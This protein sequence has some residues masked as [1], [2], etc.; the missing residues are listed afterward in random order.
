MKRFIVILSFLSGIFSILTAG[1]TGK[2]AGTV[3]D[4]Q[5]GEPLIGVNIILKGTHLGAATDEDGYY[6]II[7]IPPGEYDLEA[8]YL[9]YHTVIIKKVMVKVD[10]TTEINIKMEP[11]SIKGPTIEVVAQN[12]IIQK[13]ITSTRKITSGKEMKSLP[14]FESTQDVF[15]LYGG[16]ILDLRPQTLQLANGTRIQVRDESLR[17]V[18]IRGG[19]GGEILYLVDGVPVTHPIYGGRSVLDLNI[20]DVQEIELLTGAFNAEYGQAQSGVINITTRSGGQK[21]QGGIEYKTDRLGVFGESYNTDYVSFFASGP[22]PLSNKIFPQLKIKF[23]GEMFFFLSG[24]FNLTDTPYNNHRTREVISFNGIK[25]RERQENDANLNFKLTWNI[26]TKLRTDIS[27]HGAWKKWSN[28]DWLWKN[29]PDHMADF[30]RSTQ[31]LNLKFSHTLSKSTF[32]NL[33]IGFLGVKYDGSLNGMKPPDFWKF[34]KDSSDYN[35]GIWYDYEE[36]EKKFQPYQKPFKV[37]SSIKS[38]TFDPLTGFFDSQ[39]YDNLWRDDATKTLTLR[40]NLSSQ[41]HPEHFVKTGIELQ[42]N[43]LQYIDIQDGGVKLSLYGIAKYTSSQNRPLPPRPPGPFPEF[44]QNRW[45]FRVKP[46]M[47]AWYIQDKFEKETLI[48]NA[49]IRLDWFYLGKTIMNRDWKKQ[50]ER[51]TGLQSNWKVLKYKFSPRF[52]ISFPISEDMVV[53]FSYGHFNQLPELQFYYRDPYTGSFTGNPHLDYEQTILYEFGL[54]RRISRNWAIDI[55][56]YNKDISK[57]VGTT[58]LRGNLG[59]PVYLY[60]NKGYAR[61]RGI[62]IE[63]K[64]RYFK[65]IGGRLNYTV[66]WATGYSSS[67][68]DDYIRSITDFPNPIRERRVNW[69]VR[70]QVIFE[71]SIVIPNKIYRIFGIPFPGGW[72]LTIL[73]RF[74]SGYPY[75]PG[76]ND[77]VELQ[78]K[79]NAA[80][81][82]FITNTDIKFKKNWK[83]YKSSRLTMYL[84]IFNVFNVKNVRIGYG[85]NPWTGKP[86]RFGDVIDDS[87]QLYDWYTMYRLMDPRQFSTGRY[88]KLGVEFN[89]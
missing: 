43:D 41:I 44:G 81:G 76:S 54:T 70:H 22:E 37:E 51:V 25:F 19:R 32:Y 38:P 26:S 60:D 63:L 15:L 59:V 69:D 1:N 4:K 77:I 72:E 86:Y 9:G 64:K 11:V 89:F 74:S 49:G 67:A 56:G 30:G 23:P 8:S 82:P 47:G 48:L 73:S 20:D 75:T 80:T 33:N 17:N 78:T 61:A 83:I 79:E 85:F 7:Q 53:F 2:I 50:W 21:F 55:K 62:E 24:N 6:Y 18:H 29:Y 71:S 84:D 52:G 36:W 35:N 3:V 46:L 16:A 66:Q 27:Y 34:Y 87:P 40:L 10:L 28:F 88:T 12:K 14:G 5:T 57:Q 13:D 45:T 39:G 65:G 31:N 58:Q 42:G 68:F